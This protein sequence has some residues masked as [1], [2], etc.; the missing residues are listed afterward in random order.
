ML[1]VAIAAAPCIALLCIFP[2]GLN[3]GDRGSAD[4]PHEPEPARCEIRHT[5]RA[6]NPHYV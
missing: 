4:S 3:E 5:R 1:V 2:R 6:D